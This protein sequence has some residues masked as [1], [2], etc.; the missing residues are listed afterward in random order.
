MCVETEY[1]CR[2]CQGRTWHDDNIESV[3]AELFEGV[4]A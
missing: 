1:R 2:E 4:P 3:T